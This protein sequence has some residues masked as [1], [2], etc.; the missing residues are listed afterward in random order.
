MPNPASIADVE[1]RWR[2]LSAGQETTNAWT[3]LDDAWVMLR[4]RMTAL[5]VDV[6]ADIATDADLRDDVV[7]VISTAVLRVLRNPEG[8]SQESVDDYTY[9]R[10]EA[11]SSG[12]LYFADDE[13]DGLVPGSGAKG[14]AFMVDPLADWAAQWE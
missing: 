13:L 7:R 3:F 6:E 5:G 14:R 11:V 4:R 12:L 8:L 9:R 2:P 1:A 10:D